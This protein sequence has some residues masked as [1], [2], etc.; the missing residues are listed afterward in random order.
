MS[1][2]SYIS[3]ALN[4]TAETLS[5]PYVCAS[6]GDE[7]SQRLQSLLDKV[8]L[9]KVTDNT[10][11]L[12][13]DIDKQ[14]DIIPAI[15]VKRSDRLFI[16]SDFGTLSRRQIEN[17]VTVLS[18]FG[19]ISPELPRKN[20][21]ELVSSFATQ[22]KREPFVM[23]TTVGGYVSSHSAT[24]K[25]FS[26]RFTKI[27]RG[28]GIV[29]A[30]PLLAISMDRA[31]SPESIAHELVHADQFI[32]NPVS[33]YDSQEA[34]DLDIFSQ[35]LEAYHIGAR[36]RIGIEGGVEPRIP[37]SPTKIFEMQLAQVAIEKIRRQHNVDFSNP[38]EPSLLLA[39]AIKR[40]IGASILHHEL[41][42]DEA[43]R[44]LNAAAS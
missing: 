39:R 24:F 40:A 17:A 23:P 22:G 11:C 6:L 43:M 9:A 7:Q 33:L 15:A 4:D 38:F 28:F 2:E 21:D 18:E 29:R 3:E 37:Y 44:D 14:S 36:V 12:P 10:I 31:A 13:E 25:V 42:Y 26:S 16:G 19:P 8:V 30:I 20:V 5:D 32:T 41:K 1:R 34:I 35:E 27:P